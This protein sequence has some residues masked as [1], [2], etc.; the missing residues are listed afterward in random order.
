M[1]LPP[2]LAGATV[3]AFG[4]LV[5]PGATAPVSITGKATCWAWGVWAPGIGLRV[6]ASLDAGVTWAT[7]VTLPDSGSVA[8]AR[9]ISAPFSGATTSLVRL[10]LDSP[11]PGGYVNWAM[12]Q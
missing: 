11:F 6:E 3:V 10:A 2:A 9:P 7:V 1:I 5:A 4:A 8:E 12:T